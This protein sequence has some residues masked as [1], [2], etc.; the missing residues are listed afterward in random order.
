MR[1]NTRFTLV[2]IKLKNTMKKI[3]YLFLAFILICLIT[4]CEKD[5][6]KD[7][8]KQESKCDVISDYLDSTYISFN[9]GAVKFNYNYLFGGL[10]AS[11]ERVSNT[12]SVIIGFSADSNIG[13]KTIYIDFYFKI[14]ELDLKKSDTTTRADIF[15]VSNFDTLIRSGNIDFRNDFINVSRIGIKISYFDNYGNLQSTNIDK[16]I[17]TNNNVIIPKDQMNS[18]SS[19]CIIERQ[20]LCNGSFLL[21]GKF[22]TDIYNLTENQFSKLTNGEFCILMYH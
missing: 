8:V 17:E 20:D 3:S 6:D 5:K 10:G 21:K 1:K 15:K 19:Y 9:Q 12:D 7:E 2:N 22:E 18:K 14:S 4:R 11:I 16:D 13:N